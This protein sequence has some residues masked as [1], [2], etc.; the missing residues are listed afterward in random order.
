MTIRVEREALLRVI[1]RAPSAPS[2]PS[3]SSSSPCGP[4]IQPEDDEFVIVELP[5][6]PFK[7]DGFFYDDLIP[8]STDDDDQASLCSLSTDS[9]SSYSSGDTTTTIDR[10]RV[11]FAPDL[12][13]D[14]W[15]RDKTLPED[16]SMLY[17]SSQ[18]TQ[19]FR[20]EYRLERKVLNELSIDPETFPVDE[21]ELSNLVAA[22]SATSP[23][24]SGSSRHRISRVVV[25][26]NDKLETFFNPVEDEQEQAAEEQSVMFN[27]GATG[28]GDFFDNDSFW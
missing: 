23:S 8:A 3:S 14:V 25:L 17:Y 4:L 12:V 7:G 2:S 24:S 28:A 9:D 15:T 13:T 21:E 22:S 5:Q 1:S 26:H 20:Q 16:V 19:T 11:S 10:P 18:E 27:G 6:K